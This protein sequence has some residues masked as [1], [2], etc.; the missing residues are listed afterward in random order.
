VVPQLRESKTDI[1]LLA[2]H[3]MEK[4]SSLHGK[5]IEQISPQAAEL[6]TSYNWP[7]NVREL[8]NC[9]E[10]AL[11]LS[12]DG[13]I[14]SYHLPPPLQKEQGAS[15]DKRLTLKEVVERVER[16]LIT[17]ELRRTRGNIF[18]AAAN[19]GISKRIMGLRVEKYKLKGEKNEKE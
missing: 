11:I 8:E 2:D 10:R 15:D 5:E 17:E 1:K 13:V 3:F 18:R 9:V 12:T 14:H 19:L 16:E 6:L 7:G 4:F